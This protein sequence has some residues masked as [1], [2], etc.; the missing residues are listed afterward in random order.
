MIANINIV[1]L[2]LVKSKLNYVV[3]VV[4]F[5]VVVVVKFLVITLA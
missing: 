3:V 1:A 2:L 4:K 5:M